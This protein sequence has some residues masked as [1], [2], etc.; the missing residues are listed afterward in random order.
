M[1]VLFLFFL[2]VLFFYYTVYGVFPVSPMVQ[3][4]EC[5]AAEPRHRDALQNILA[6]LESSFIMIPI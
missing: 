5:H 6:V 1:S 3:R 4:R 2:F